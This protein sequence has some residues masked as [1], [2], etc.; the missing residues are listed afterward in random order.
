MLQENFLNRGLLACL[1]FYKT[2]TN[3]PRNLL[4]QG[5]PWLWASTTGNNCWHRAPNSVFSPLN[6]KQKHFS[7]WVKLPFS[8][9]SSEDPEPQWDAVF[10][11]IK[12]FWF[13]PLSFIVSEVIIHWLKWKFDRSVLRGWFIT[14]DYLKVIFISNWFFLLYL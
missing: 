2:R 11:L 8:I 7:F 13:F 3:L 10:S 6:L 5:T 12:L 4:L 14:L 1:L 9:P